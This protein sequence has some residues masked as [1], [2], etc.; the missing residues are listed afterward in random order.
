[1]A[2]Q[3]QN[4]DGDYLDRLR[5]GDIG[6]QQHFAEYFGELIRLKAAKRLRSMAAVEDVRQETLT[7]VLRLLTE[8]RLRQPECLGAF[9]NSVCNNV[10]HEYHHARTRELPADD[11]VVNAILDPGMSALEAVARQQL[12]QKVR[13]ILEELPE[14]DRCLLKAVFLEERSKDE[15]CCEFGVTRDYLRVLVHRAKE[16]FKSYYL[17]ATRKLPN[18]TR[19][20]HETSLREHNNRTHHTEPLLVIQGLKTVGRGT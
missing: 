8:Q 9:V 2:M 15:L 12:Q 7:R 18:R 13:Q 1:M 19:I 4:F 20:A 6:T 11:E 5:S 16:S 3:F 17:D 10:L 14:K